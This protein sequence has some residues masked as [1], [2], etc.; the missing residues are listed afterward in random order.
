MESEPGL[1]RS[2]PWRA[3]KAYVP[4]GSSSAILSAFS[5]ADARPG[6]ASLLGAGSASAR[7]PGRDI[8]EK[9]AT[10]ELGVFPD[11]GLLS[12]SDAAGAVVGV[13]PSGWAVG[14]VLPYRPGRGSINARKTSADLLAVWAPSGAAEPL[15]APQQGRRAVKQERLDALAAWPGTDSDCDSSADASALRHAS[16]ALASAQGRLQR[17][18]ADET[19]RRRE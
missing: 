8:N 4:R 12:H 19:R 18:A 10:K 9:D 7:V 3:G 2:T 6:P 17:Y 1:F 16:S 11:R 14:R 15:A 5:D 13:T